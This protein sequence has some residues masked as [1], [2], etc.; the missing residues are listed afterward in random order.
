MTVECSALNQHLHILAVRDAPGRGGGE[1]VRARGGDNPL[2]NS[3][4]LDTIGKLN[5]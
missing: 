1:R 3:A 2:G 4:Y 5:M